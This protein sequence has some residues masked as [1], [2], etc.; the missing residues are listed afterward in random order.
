MRVAQLQPHEKMEAKHQGSKP[1]S[2]LRSRTVLEQHLLSPLERL[3]GDQT[4]RLP[5]ETFLGFL[6]SSQN[7]M[8]W[9]VP[10]TGLHGKGWLS[11]AQLC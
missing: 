3:R 1:P 5:P 6:L 11:G 2:R 7:I 8:S 10:R 9:M 4:A